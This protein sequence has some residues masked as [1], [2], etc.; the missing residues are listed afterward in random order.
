MEVWLFLCILSGASLAYSIRGAVYRLFFSPIAHFPGPK[1]AA[2]TFWYE[3]YYDVV[4]SGSYVWKILE[5]HERYGMF[6]DS[7]R[8]A[9][10]PVHFF[11]LSSNF[12][13]GAIQFLIIVLYWNTDYP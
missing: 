9:F 1:L 10:F 6:R 13:I 12:L 3:F 7:G 5:M 4:L 2:V 11:L 8:A